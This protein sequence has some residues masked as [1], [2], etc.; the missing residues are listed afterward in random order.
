MKW[1][2]DQAKQHFRE[3]LRAA[4][5]EPQQI[6]D[7]QRLIAVLIDGPTFKEAGAW[8]HLQ[9]EPTLTERFAELRRICAEESWEMPPIERGAAGGVDQNLGVFEVSEELVLT[10]GEG[11]DPVIGQSSQEDRPRKASELRR[12]SAR[13]PA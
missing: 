11:L 1:T 3:V 9:Q 8:R 13:E 7:G 4:E 10:L 2:V 6:W 12:G 5:N